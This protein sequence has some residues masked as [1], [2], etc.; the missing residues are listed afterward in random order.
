MNK[1]DTKTIFFKEY[2]GFESC[3][4]IYRDVAEML[5]PR[6]NPEAEGIGGEF[7]GTIKI[8]VTYCES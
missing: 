3:A 1:E 4:D 5:D 6:F 8:E 2:H 7:Q